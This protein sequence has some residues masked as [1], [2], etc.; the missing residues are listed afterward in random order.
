MRD[1][2]G[3]V[4][5]ITGG[6]AG[7]GR[8]AAIACARAGAKVAFGGRNPDEGEETR[9]LVQAEGEGFY[10]QLDVTDND[11][12]RSFVAATVAKYGK[13]DCALNNAGQSG[14]LRALADFD[15]AAA[16][17]L[18]DVNFKGVF[19]AMK[20]EIPELIKAG[21]GSIVNTGSVSSHMGVGG[22]SIYAGTKHAVWGMTKTAALEYGPD[23]VRI[24]MVAPAGVV[25]RMSDLTLTSPEAEKFA[26]SFHALGRLGQPIEVVEAVLWLF[27][28][29]SSFV[30]GQTIN[31][32]GGMSSGVAGT[33]ALAKDPEALG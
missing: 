29:R 26:A 22:M 25:T 27:S 30:T 24:N 32:D 7:I 5:L 1:L 13:L 6:T 15:V 33:L 18:I 8:A 4:V 20:A 31:V 14:E 21:G 9:D 12:V 2:E 11:S 10:Q 3:K 28:H 23:G 19:Y 16:S 17:Q